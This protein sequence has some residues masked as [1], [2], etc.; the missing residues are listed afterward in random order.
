MKL[1]VNIPLFAS[2]LS[3]YHPVIIEGMGSYDP[4]DPVVVA[5]QI[6]SRLLSHWSSNAI[7]KPMLL[8]TQGDPLSERGISAITPLVAGLLGISRGL[9]VMDP[10]LAS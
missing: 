4:R 7:S 2:T 1:S 3:K 6:H 9:V 10:H 8:V 5:K